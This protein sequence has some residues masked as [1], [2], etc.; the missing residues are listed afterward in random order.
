MLRRRGRCRPRR[1]RGCL[2][3]TRGRPGDGELHRLPR[4]CLGRHGRTRRPRPLP[5]PPR[6]RDLGGLTPESLTRSC[7][8]HTAV[9]PRSRS[10]PHRGADGRWPEH[11]RA[12][13]RRS[14]GGRPGL[15]GRRVQDG[16]GTRRADPHHPRRR[17][18]IRRQPVRAHPIPVSRAACR[19]YARDVQAEVDRYGLALPEEPIEDDDH[20][21]DKIDLLTSAPVPWVSFTFGVPDRV[22]VSALRRAGST[23]L[24][25]V[26]SA[27]E[28]RRAA[29][30]GV[31][32]DRVRR[33][34][35]APEA[36]AAV[37]GAGGEEMPP[38]GPL[39]S[40]PP[41]REPRTDRSDQ[42][43]VHSA[44]PR[45]TLRSE[46]SREANPY[47]R[48]RRYSLART[49]VAWMIPTV[50]ARC[51]SERSARWA[52]ASSTRASAPASG[53]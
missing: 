53:R 9:R 33:R 14:P 12:G 8:E 1:L 37:G 46:Q 22:A 15:P 2:G 44:D 38:A 39:D 7:H 49:L 47:R 45:P 35:E 11:A 32:G 51:G 50:R 28:A 18:R 43:E 3:C 25:C 16:T 13:H 41:L 30:A 10:S 26:T 48:E 42:A 4:R 31:V 27:D 6:P 24:Q 21:T 52:T 40:P 17:R 36:V 19:R 29:D 34:G 23:L 20:W 5:A